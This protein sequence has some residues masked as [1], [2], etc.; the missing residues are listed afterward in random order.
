[1]N[2]EKYNS[3][4]VAW[5]RMNSAMVNGFFLE[6]VA[7]QESI[8]FDRLRSFLTFAEKQDIRDDTPLSKIITRW[9][10]VLNKSE[11]KFGPWDQ[12]KELIAAVRAWGHDRNRVV[13]TVVRSQ[14]GFPTK[15][16]E[17]F[18][19]H[20]KETAETGLKLVRR[21]DHWFR[22]QKTKSTPSIEQR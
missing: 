17:E 22:K 6:A 10:N 12:D 4:K 20:S 13:H 3:Y 11:K 5:E 9:E 18:L 16:I 8:I 19:A 7:I 14:P 15:P 2:Y 21:I 1:M